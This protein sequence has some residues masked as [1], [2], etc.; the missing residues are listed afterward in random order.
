MT[1]ASAIITAIAQNIERQLEPRKHAQ[2]RAIL[3][4]LTKIATRTAPAPPDG[5]RRPQRSRR[6]P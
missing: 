6:S 1:A 5:A 3:E 2:L 4:D